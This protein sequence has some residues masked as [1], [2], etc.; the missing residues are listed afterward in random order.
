MVDIITAAIVRNKFATN[1][2]NTIINEAYTSERASELGIPSEDLQSSDSINQNA[3]LGAEISREKIIQASSVYN[4]VFNTVSKMLN[5]RNVTVNTYFN[6]NG[7]NALKSSKSGK[8][9]FNDELSGSGVNTSSG[10]QSLDGVSNPFSIGQVI[11]ESG[12]DSLYS[13]M[14]NQWKQYC[15]N[16]I[17]YSLYTCHSSC[18]SNCHSSG[19]GRR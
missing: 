7:T 15:N 12:M 4:A 13:T 3:Q 5:V 10:K 19:R 6:T 18:H 2:T 8:A 11:T 1:V 16:T 17:T 14:L 9:A